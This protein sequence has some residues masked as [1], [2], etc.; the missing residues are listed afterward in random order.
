MTTPPTNARREGVGQVRLYAT[1][2]KL[3]MRPGAYFVAYV[4][5][6]GHRTRYSP[7]GRR[8]YLQR[9]ALRA[10]VAAQV[11]AG[12][13][14][15]IPASCFLAPVR[16]HAS[17]AVYLIPSRPGGRGDIDNYAKAVLDAVQPLWLPN[18]R[19]VTELHVE[20]RNAP[21]PRPLREPIEWADVTLSWAIQERASK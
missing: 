13:L 3:R 19:M 15:K 12:A 14:A 5:L 6:A 9:D 20:L 7:G 4:R 21:A 8:Y 18:D 17:I 16:V 10:Q 1:Y 11:A 2:D